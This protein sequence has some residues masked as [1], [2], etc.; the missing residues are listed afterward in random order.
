MC[1]SVIVGTRT[2]ILSLSH[3]L[4]SPPAHVCMTDKWPA[5]SYSTG[6]QLILSP[7]SCPLFDRIS[8]CVSRLIFGNQTLLWIPKWY[9]TF[10]ST[11]SDL[12]RTIS[13]LQVN[14]LW[15]LSFLHSRVSEFTCVIR[16]DQNGSTLG[17]RVSISIPTPTST[18]QVSIP[19]STS[20]YIYHFM[21]A[22]HFNF[23]FRS[24]LLHNWYFTSLLAT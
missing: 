16:R 22:F 20:F 12:T 14:D 15:H 23:I 13:F 5:W 19:L 24:Q 17:S 7:F 3:R 1:D 6:T 4:R 11:M 9:L 8:N 18:T 10:S 2:G 21:T